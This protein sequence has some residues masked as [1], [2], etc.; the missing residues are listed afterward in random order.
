MD[1][2]QIATI[3]KNTYPFLAKEDLDQ[4]LQIGQYKVL[5]NKEAIIQAGQ[6]SNKVFFILSGMIRGYF[7][8]AKAT[9]NAQAERHLLLCVDC[10]M[11]EGENHAQLTVLKAF[12]TKVWFW[13]L[14]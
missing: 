9:Q 4:L 5:K 12:R 2:T 10:R 6:Y 8:N 1:S 3:L 11:A 14:R 7:I 13:H